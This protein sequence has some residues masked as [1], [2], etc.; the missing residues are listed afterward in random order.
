M[1]SAEVVY[2]IGKFLHSLLPKKFC[3]LFGMISFGNLKVFRMHFRSVV[4]N[5]EFEVG[6]MRR[7]VQDLT[8]PFLFC[9][10]E[11]DMG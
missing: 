1:A 7:D 10:M 4:V 2:K 6:K 9:W 3:K 11:C 5:Y 8:L